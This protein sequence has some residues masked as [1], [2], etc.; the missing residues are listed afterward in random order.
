MINIGYLY[1]YVVGNLHPHLM[2]RQHAAS[3]ALQRETAFEEK[4]LQ[5]MQDAFPKK[6]KK[7]KNRDPDKLF[8][9][10]LYEEMKRVPED[11]R[12]D[13][14]SELIQVLKKYQ[15]KLPIKQEKSQH[16]HVQ[17]A[18]SS[19]K[20][21]CTATGGV[22]GGGGN[23]NGGT[24]DKITLPQHGQISHSMYQLQKKYDKN[25]KEP[26]PQSQVERVQQHNREH[27]G[28]GSVSLHASQQIPHAI[29]QLQKKFEESA[30]EKVHQQT[31][32]RKHVDAP[33]H[34]QHPAAHQQPPPPAPPNAN[35]PSQQQH[36]HHPQ[37]PHGI[38]FPLPQIRNEQPGGPQHHPHNPHQQQQSQQAPQQHSHQQT[39]QQHLPPPI[40]GNAAATAPGMSTDRPTMAYEN[41]G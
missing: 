1:I 16:V 15:R 31:D 25:E 34:Q 24:G 3:V 38:M 22:V 27:T 6:T 13:V 9:L 4:F 11:I 7:R 8:L 20:S 10:S 37:M 14:K 41:V 40:F 26:S 33:T 18:S 12:L 35:D 21:S 28:A 30:V 5:F 32:Q 17:A 36:L 39:Q 19:S 29:F 23:G 2:R